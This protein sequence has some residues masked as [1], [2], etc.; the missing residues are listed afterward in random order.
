M[1]RDIK[2]LEFEG[3]APTVF[4][5]L[6]FADQGAQVVL[7]GRKEQASFSIKVDQNLMNRGKNWVT[8]SPK[9][10]EERKTI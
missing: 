10:K 7:V 9:I 6:Y 5:G 1:L 8:L 4:C 2:V 3:L